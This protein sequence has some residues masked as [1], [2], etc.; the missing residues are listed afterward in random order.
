MCG[1]L[2]S[3]ESRTIVDNLLYKSWVFKKH[4]VVAHSAYSQQD[5]S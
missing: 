1:S 5:T 3:I 2:S 4:E